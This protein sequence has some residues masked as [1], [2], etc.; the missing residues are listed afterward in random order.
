MTKEQQTILND[1]NRRWL[2]A[3]EPSL[4]DLEK[5][6][7][8]IPCTQVVITPTRNYWRGETME[9]LNKLRVNNNKK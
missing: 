4:H 7:V 6:F 5:V 8:G 9:L 3:H 2:L 1:P